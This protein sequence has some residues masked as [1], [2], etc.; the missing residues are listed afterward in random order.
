MTA[1]TLVLQSAPE[2]V[3]DWMGRCLASVR[4]WAEHQGLGY[5]FLDDEIFEALPDGLL[6]KVGRRRQMAADLARLLEIRRLLENG[7]GRVVWLD[8]DVFLPKIEVPMPN[9]GGAGYLIGREVWI[10]PGQKGC[11]AYTNCHNAFLRFDAGNPLLDF[12]IHTTGRLLMTADLSRV[13][14]QFAGPKLLSALH[15]ISPFD[16]TDFVAMASPLVLRDLATGGGAALE[17]LRHRT[18]GEIG[19]WNLCGSL[20]GRVSDGI[21]VTDALLDRAMTA[22]SAGNGSE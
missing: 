21:D 10:Q 1:D 11:K 20:S 7:A 6:E 12:L 19:G 22:L 16:L 9:D 18:E 14:P 13:P 17:M 4:A 2:T 3:P 5:R 8:A 15:G